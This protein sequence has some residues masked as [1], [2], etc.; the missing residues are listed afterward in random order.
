MPKDWDHYVIG[1][2]LPPVVILD[3]RIQRGVCVVSG[4]SA[5]P[6]SRAAMGG[7]CHDPRPALPRP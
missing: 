3:R 1:P 5:P 4:V 7:W 6:D 2:K